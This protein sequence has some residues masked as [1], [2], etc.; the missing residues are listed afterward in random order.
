M[1]KP[2]KIAILSCN[3]GHA[4]GYYVLKNDPLFDLVGVSVK[5]GYDKV[6][7][8]NTIP[9]V[10]KYATDEELYAAHPDLE[11][12][13]IAS[14]N[15]SHLAQVKEAA[16]RGL[17]I[18]SMKIPSFDMDEYREMIRVTEEA[19][20]AVQ[21]ELEMRHHAPL[22]RVRELIRGGALGKLLSINMVNYS[23]NPVWWRPWQCDP[24]ESYGKEVPLRPE[25]GR[26]RGG[27]LADH[28]HVFDAIRF[29][30]GSS[31]ENIYAD[32]A[33]NPRAEVKTEDLV[34]VIGTLRDGTVFSIDPS[35]GNDEHR[36]PVQIDWEKYPRCVEVF[37]TAVGTEGVIVADLYGRTYFSQRGKDSEYMCDSV[38]S[39]GLWN[40]RTQE[41]YD[42]IRLGAQPPVG[43]RDHFE[44]VVAMNAAYDSISTGSVV[45]LTDKDLTI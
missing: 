31:F 12:V 13:I 39:S 34:R 9:E 20:I 3:H 2:V 18:F 32:A 35:Y 10:P 41:F 28:P 14:D 25:D 44:T 23:H 26:F 11:A 19:G 38:G 30:T 36:V 15:K 42:C 27:A 16:A 5:A 40:R 37:M 1:T 8:L 17:H 21:V 45:T 24:V 22:Y 6:I 7:G 4:K 43:L 33:P 29:V